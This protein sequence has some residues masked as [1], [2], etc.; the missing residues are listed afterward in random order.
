M[1]LKQLETMRMMCEQAIAPCK[2]QSDPE[3]PIKDDLFVDNRTLTSKRESKAQDKRQAKSEEQESVPLA[4]WTKLV[5]FQVVDAA[6]DTSAYVDKEGR[7]FTHVYSYNKVM[8][9][10]DMEGICK[11]LNRTEWLVLAW[12]FGPEA[13]SKFGLVDFEELD[14]FPMH[15]TGKENFTVFVYFK[16]KSAA[17]AD[18]KR[19]KSVMKHEIKSVRKAFKSTPKEPT[20]PARERRNTRLASSD[21]KERR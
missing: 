13:T 15:S 8:S 9:P 16:T 21:K 7:H 10:S 4:D 6:K 19:A 14:K 1:F 17:K 11:I 12:Y 5:E 20:T 2:M 3:L 18:P